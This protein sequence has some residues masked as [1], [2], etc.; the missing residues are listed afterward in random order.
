M[1]LL[2]HTTHTLTP[3]DAW[4]VTRRIV[5]RRNGSGRVGQ[6]FQVMEKARRIIHARFQSA[7][8]RGW[9]L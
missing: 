7:V 9:K 4:R 1:V 8:E 5:W 2:T 6:E 3:D